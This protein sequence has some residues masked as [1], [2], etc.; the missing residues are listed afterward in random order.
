VNVRLERTRT[1]DGGDCSKLIDVRRL[2]L[3]TEFSSARCRELKDP[4]KVTL[5]IDMLPDC[6]VILLYVSTVEIVVKEVFDI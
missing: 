1:I 5:V 2:R 3:H 6:G 4:N